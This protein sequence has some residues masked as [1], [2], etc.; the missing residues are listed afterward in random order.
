MVVG[1]K[2][3]AIQFEKPNSPAGIA[4][5]HRDGVGSSITALNII[6]F[7]VVAENLFGFG[8]QPNVSECV[9]LQDYNGFVDD[10]ARFIVQD[11]IGELFGFWVV[12]AH[13]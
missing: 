5:E 13:P 8:D 4:T 9:T 6:G 12:T 1:R 3:S 11:N 10:L 7:G 2:E